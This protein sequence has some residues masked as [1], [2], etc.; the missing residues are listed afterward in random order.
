MAETNNDYKKVLSPS[1]INQ[2]EDEELRKIR[3][4]YW[5]LRH[6]AFLDEEIPE[7]D[8]DMVIENL[9]KEEQE[10]ME[11]YRKNKN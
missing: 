10:K 4:K 7:D 9:F 8:L 6:D 11:D 1:E 3:L 5:K 2:I